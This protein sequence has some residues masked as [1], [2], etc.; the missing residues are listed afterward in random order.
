MGANLPKSPIRH[1]LL[2]IVISQIKIEFWKKGI[3]TSNGKVNSSP[4]G[5]GGGVIS[6]PPTSG[7]DFKAPGANL[8]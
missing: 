3:V 6:A 8:S 1:W 5:E 7:M 2:L 4:F